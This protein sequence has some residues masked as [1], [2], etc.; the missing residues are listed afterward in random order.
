MARKRGGLAGF[1]DRNKGV[2][3]AAAPFIAGAVGGPLAGAAVGAAMRGF[4]REGQSGIG[5][6]LGQ[7]LQGGISGY[8]AGALGA[9]ARS[10]FTGKLAERAAAKGLQAG[11]KQLAK[12]PTDLVS[13]AQIAGAGAGAAPAMSMAPAAAPTGGFNAASYLADNASQGASRAMQLGKG[14]ST[15]TPAAPNVPFYKTKEGMEFIG[16]GMTAGP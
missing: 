16:K 8:G 15:T 13:N 6:D 1:Y 11:T 14:V 10:M 5:F 2:L 3:Q 4:D 9:G 7:G 12:L